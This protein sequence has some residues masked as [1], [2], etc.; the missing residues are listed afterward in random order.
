VAGLFVNGYKGAEARDD[1]RVGNLAKREWVLVYA[2]DEATSAIP[3]S[4]LADINQILEDNNGFTTKEERDAAMRRRVD[5]SVFRSEG[6]QAV[7]RTDE[8]SCLHFWKNRAARQ[9]KINNRL[10]TFRIE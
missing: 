4:V 7:M 10:S 5:K 1:A 9:E 3:T 2:I 6:R 8:S